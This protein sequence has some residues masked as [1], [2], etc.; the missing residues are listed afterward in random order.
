MR[1]KS[2]F[3]SENCKMKQKMKHTTLIRTLFLTLVFGLSL[4]LPSV[5]QTIVKDYE[6]GVS[7]DGI[8]YFLPKT[9]VDITLTTA[10]VSYIPGEL[11]S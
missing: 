6:P 2:Y 10:K 5:A 3:C 4:F 7:K 11:C 9:A 8:V 1:K